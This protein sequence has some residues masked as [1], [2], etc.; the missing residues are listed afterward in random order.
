MASRWI[1]LKRRLGYWL[2]HR[3]RATWLEDEIAFHLDS[4]VQDLIAQGVPEREAR[5]MARRK[6][7]DMIRTAEDARAT[8]VARWWSDFL[9]DLRLTA[10]TMRRDVGFTAFVILI[11]GL[12]IGASATVFSVVNAMLLRPLPFRDP[13]ALVWISNDGQNHQE[14]TTQVGHVVDM[15]D[16]ATSFEDLAGWDN[17]YH[18]GDSELTGVGEPD[19]VTSVPVTQN[20]F[21]LLGVAPEVGRFFT[22]DEARRPADTPPAVILS[23]RFWVQRFAGDPALVGRTLTLNSASVLVVGVLPASFDF[24]SVFTPGVA[25][26]VFVPWP[27]TDQTNGQ[28][29]TTRI[30]ARLRRGVTAAQAQAELDTIAPGIVKRHP[31]RNGLYPV[32]VPLSTRISGSS[33][34]AL[35]VLAGAVAVVLLI[36]C[37][38]L[39][40]LQIARLGARKKE[41]AVRVALGAGRLRLL[42]QLLTES[43]VLAC[44]GGIFGVGLAILGTRELSRLTAL[45]LPLLAA[46]GVDARA[47]VFSLGITVLTGVLFGVLPAFQVRSI[48]VGAELKDGARGS[49]RGGR[50]WI[51]SALV[52]SEIA[53]ACL[54]LVGTGLLTRSFLRVLDVDLG[55]EPEHVVALRADPSFRLANL[56]QANAFMD[57]VLMRTRTLAGVQAA[58]FTDAL[59]F[60]GDRSWGMRGVG[61]VYAPGHVPEA[62]IRVVTDGYFEA[63]G[64]AVRQGRTFTA[65]DRAT[66]EKVVVM[67]ETLARTLWP[68]E[69][70]IGQRINQRDTPRVIGVVA[71]VRHAALEEDSG[72]ELYLP[73]R[74]TGDFSN[75]QLVVRSTLSEPA[76]AEK[77][78]SALRP[79]DPNLP[80]HTLQ[81][82]QDLVDRAVSPRRFIVMVLGGFAGFALLLASLGIYAV[83]SQSVSQRTQEIGIR[84][85]LGA[86]AIDVQRRVLAGTLGLAG[87]G[88][89]IGLV[90]S[91]ALTAALG[92]LLFGV[93]PGDPATF[94]V[95]TITLAVV[96][97]AAG[98]LPAW[99]ASRINPMVTLRSS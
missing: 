50:A 10:R 29:N 8:W 77:L 43:V 37:A 27:L 12:G 69:D 60:A 6:F 20:L 96:A 51:R 90:L 71:D 52:V 59:P 92:S 65:Q 40:N 82:L 41:M 30:V 5:A 93:T 66:T 14:W 39:S 99:R 3:R 44:G 85:A 33:G 19:R 63:A 58:G 17:F 88:L 47:I 45:K 26:D 62:Y 83:I 56:E 68:G 80:V 67:N 48:S 79:V 9:Q 75:M 86:S 2:A 38:N 55:F 32:V 54:L 61:Q 15:R 73:M 35:M 57:D 95:M 21:A 98:F 78:R 13:G 11:A 1:R 84:M 24:S 34:P 23:H 4:M 94:V 31:E 81:P 89:A 91:R 25:A 42:R 22:E 74:Q 76:L 36:V 97:G 46:V 28:G 7:G 72:G 49:T 53:L 64:I 87:L 70:A 18:V 16:T